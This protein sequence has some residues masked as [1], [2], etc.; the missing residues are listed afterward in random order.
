MGLQRREVQVSLLVFQGLPPQNLRAVH[1]DLQKAEQRWQ[2]VFMD[3]ELLEKHC[4]IK[5][6]SQE[7][8]V[9]MGNL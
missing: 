2:E 4:H 9:G 8:G 5:E 3:N 7:V 1:P 6:A